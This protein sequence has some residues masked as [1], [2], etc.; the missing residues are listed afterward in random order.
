MPNLPVY[1]IKPQS[2]K[3]KMKTL[4]RHHLLPIRDFVWIPVPDNT[5]V[6]QTRPSAKVHAKKSHERAKA[7]HSMPMECGKST[8]SSDIECD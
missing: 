8:E 2:G 7:E 6:V 3:G 5:E 1:K 4:L